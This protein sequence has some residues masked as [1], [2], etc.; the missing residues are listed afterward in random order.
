VARDGHVAGL[1]RTNFRAGLR[2]I[3]IDDLLVR[4]NGAMVSVAAN[5]A[6]AV[7][8]WLWRRSSVPRRGCWLL[9]GTWAVLAS[10]RSWCWAGD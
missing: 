2:E 6:G 10:M 1:L 7:L 9:A 4:D 3:M 5:A 8:F